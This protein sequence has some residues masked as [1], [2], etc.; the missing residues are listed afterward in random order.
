LSVIERPQ[1]GGAQQALAHWSLAAIEGMKEGG[2]RVLAGDQRLDELEVAD[3][4]WIELELVG[5]LDE[6]QGIE[7]Q[8]V[9]FLRGL[10]VVE[11]DSG[12]DGCAGMAVQAEAFEGFDAEFAFD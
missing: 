9:E 12:G 8:G 3:G 4:Y 10:D 2:A 6:A 7:V 1:D 5:A 11:D